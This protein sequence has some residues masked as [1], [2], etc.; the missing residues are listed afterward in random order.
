MASDNGRR[1]QV[2]PPRV[3]LT[4]DHSAALREQ[5]I[6]ELKEL[7]DP[8]ALAVWAQG[9][10]TLKNQLTA[11]DAQEVETAFAAKLNA[12]GADVA[13]PDTPESTTR[14]AG[15]GNNEPATAVASEG[16]GR[17]PAAATEKLTPRASSTA[18][19]CRGAGLR[20]KMDHRMAQHPML[21]FSRL[22]RCASQSGCG[23]G[24]I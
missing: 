1:K 21:P 6:S 19:A 14:V 4:A 10:L 7:T 22:P 24:I 15:G 11:S 23:T 2:R 17:E 13:A 3:L 5:L 8:D 12:L 18:I 16:S 9:S 20:A